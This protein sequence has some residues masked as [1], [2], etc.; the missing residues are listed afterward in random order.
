MLRILEQKLLHSSNTE[1]RLKFETEGGGSWPI[2]D[3]FIS[4][5]GKHAY[6]IGNIC[7]TCAF[8]FR[9]MGGANRSV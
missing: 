7:Q 9:R 5:D 8:L 1:S 3:R 6:N 4:L 2:W